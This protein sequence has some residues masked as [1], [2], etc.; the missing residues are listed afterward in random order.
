MS[1][2]SHMRFL[3]L[4]ERFHSTRNLLELDSCVVASARYSTQDL[5]PLTRDIIFPALRELIKAHP[6]LGVKLQNES[7][8]NPSFTR[9]HT[10]DLSRVVDFGGSEN[11]RTAL[12]SQLAQGFNTGADLPL[13]RVQVLADN[14]VVFAV[15][16]VIGDGLST[17][18][19]HTSLLRALRN[20]TVADASSFVRVSDTL[21]LPPPIETVTTTQP[22]L[23]TTFNE[24]Y[25]LFAPKY[26]TRAHSAWSGNPVP[27]VGSLRTNVRLLAIPAQDLAVFCANCRTHCATL[28]SA[29]YILTVTIISR[30]LAGDS[31]H[32]TISSAVAISLRGVTGIPDSAICD[33]VSAHFTY[34][35]TNSKFSWTAAARYAATLRKQKTKARENIGMLRFLFGHYAPYMRSHG[36]TKRANGFA[37]SN[38]GRFDAPA[39]EGSW[40][41]VNTVFAQC[42]VVIGAAFK[43]N[44]VR[45]P[46]GALS[47]ALTY[48]EHSIDSI[49]VESFMSQFRDTFYDLIS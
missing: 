21:F 24:L 4:L 1:S 43:L 12:E 17:V 38:L 18:A 48:G 22:S 16:H 10:I 34:P 28:T 41:I 11:L 32:Q 26:W 8:S 7:N 30:M 49:F 44:V 25:K 9:L 19:F 2:D 47:I 5:R 27:K 36:G 33:C 23:S 20:L 15:H 39:V 35:A 42:D 46:A 45:D 29:F 13:W 6:P 14:T 40:N 3:G 37:L 31:R